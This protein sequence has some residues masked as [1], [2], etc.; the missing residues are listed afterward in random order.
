MPN[1]VIIKRQLLTITQ[2]S[3][4]LLLFTNFVVEEVYWENAVLPLGRIC[5]FFG[6]FCRLEG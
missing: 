2:K 5:P 1:D 3:G 6:I 4:M